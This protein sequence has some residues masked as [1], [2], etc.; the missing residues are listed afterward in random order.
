MHARRKCMEEKSPKNRNR[1]FVIGCLGIMAGLLAIVFIVNWVK[2]RNALCDLGS[3]P[4]CL[5]IYRVGGNVSG[6]SLALTGDGRY[7]AVSNMG[8]LMILDTD[9]GRV[10]AKAPVMYGEEST[11]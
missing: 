11:D 5:N 3:P 2:A 7:L 10:I 1:P 9:S 8:Q 6:N 4:Q